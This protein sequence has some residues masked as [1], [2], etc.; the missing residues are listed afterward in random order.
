MNEVAGQPKGRVTRVAGVIALVLLLVLLGM[1]TAA[2]LSRRTIARDTLVGWLERQGVP[3]EV[4]VERI[5][6]S[7]VVAR[8]RAGDPENPDLIIDRVEV[9][10]GVA[11]PWASGGVGVTPSRV[12]LV[13]PVLRARLANG[14]LSFGALDPLIEDFR[15]RPPRA[16]AAAP[17]VVVEDG[18]VRL[19]TDQGLLE[20][21]ADAR[22]ADRRL[23]SLKA[24]LP[25]QTLSGAGARLDAL[26]GALTLATE[27]D[28]VRVEGQAGARAFVLDGAAG[29]AASFRV[30]GVLPYPDAAKPMAKGPAE[31]RLA[32]E[33]GALQLGETRLSR[34]RLEG[35]L[36]GELNGW[37]DQA[38]FRGRLSLDGAAGAARAPGFTGA[39]VR[40][41]TRSAVVQGTVGDRLGWTIEGPAR[42]TAGRATALG[43]DG[44]GVDTS[45]PRIV[46]GGRGR[47]WESSG[48]FNAAARKLSW[49]DLRLARVT[50]ALNLD[51]V[52]DAGVRAEL[53]GSI[54]SPRAAWPLLG[55]PARGDLPELAEMKR[56]LSDFALT[57]PRFR[58]IADQDATTVRLGSPVVVQPRNGGRLMVQAN[59]PV[60][61]SRLGPRGGGALTLTGT[62]GAGLPELALAV[63]DWRL[64]ADG[65]TAELAGRGS[66][67]FGLARGVALRTAGV[68]T[69][70]RRG[71]AFRTTGC[72]PVTVER[73]ELGENDV[74]DLAG[75]ICSRSGP[76]VVVRNGDWRVDGRVQ[77]GSARAPFLQ[78]RFD[79]VSGPL[80][81]AGGPRG[82]ALDVRAETARAVDT[83]EP[84]RFN[85]VAATGRAALAD[86]RWTGVFDLA[87][88]DT[89][90]G[91]LALTHDSRSG[92][93]GMDIRSGEIA[94]APGGLQPG[95]L[96]P[97]AGQ[98][99][100]SP[101][102]GRVQFTGRFD[103]TASGGA[104]SGLLTIPSLD[105]QS[106]A[107]AVS[108]LT[109]QV[110]LTS[111]APLITAPDQT[112]AAAAVAGVAPLR[113]VK[114]GFEL[115][116]EALA[117]AG[118][119]VA[120]AGGRA[121]LE[122][123]RL[124]LDPM[125][126]WSGVLVLDRVQINELL[127]ASD[128][129]EKVRLDALVSGRLPFTFTPGQ[130]VR[131]AGGQLTA[132]QPGR[133]EIEREALSGLQ[134]GGGGE[135]PPNVVQDLAYQ[136][137]ED[138]AF[139]TLSAEVNSLD[140]GRLGVLFRIKG[141]FD[142]P[143]RQTLRIGVRE[144]L[145]RSY[146]NRLLPL[147]S[148]TEVDLTLDTTLNVDQLVSD[149]LAINR[150][151]SGGRP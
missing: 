18:R 75:G 81:A 151:R 126:P 19:M 17:L 33:A 61:D 118:G 7:G 121:R 147:P 116:S 29:E 129:G 72:S 2:W 138:L 110:V 22:V 149:L 131:V 102:S 135:V 16:D 144:F 82:A 105:F 78:M 36:R 79:A 8:I 143:E 62:R 114:V 140:Q 100:G 136:A 115:Q 103:W 21:A 123:F 132:V 112:L 65:F 47:T 6:L 71:L 92:V 125:A 23:H 4:E 46:V 148:G 85:P 98:W 5:E 130:G 69:S 37:L 30:S 128:V 54:A 50:G 55:P 77:D 58:L 101:A 48:R 95:D 43:L 67:D 11:W 41:R 120:L 38:A 97:L 53:G 31:L 99:V 57:A 25:R 150:A 74:F 111:L 124:P 68:L 44:R 14:R 119:E 51:L 56:A 20:I 49:G 87:R 10:Y 64:T 40:F 94:F 26:E 73:L 42:L 142:P 66:L 34:M 89:P 104:S 133:L 3:A 52:Q 70:G 15:G 1:A 109:G 60:F 137:M 45:S 59:G 9:D 139:E 93:G 88:T 146:L 28:G 39:D 86:D 35:L 117:V 96:S 12:R 145:D 122:P 134:A 108:G 80:T 113:D 91:R 27:G 90:L 107:G 106:P 76:L 127:K 63:P 141:R 32:G 84:A 24:R 83:A 13:R